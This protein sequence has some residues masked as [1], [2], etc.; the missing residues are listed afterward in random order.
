MSVLEKALEFASRGLRV[1]PV[2]KKDPQLKKWPD[3]ATT[4]QETIRSWFE[5]KYDYCD[6]FG[7]CPGREAV[8]IDVDVKNGKKGKESLAW[9]KENGLPLKTFVVKSP[10]GGLHLYYKFPDIPDGQY[11]KSVV[12]WLDLDGIDVRGTRGFVVGPTE[13][14]GY[15]IVQDLEPSVIP[16]DIKTRLPIGNVL[17]E[18]VNTKSA[19]Q[20][21]SPEGSALRGNIPN[22]IPR[23]ERHDT[24]I[25]LI[26]SWARKVS[27]DNA[28]ILL[29]TAI[30]R[31]EGLDDD[32]I[33]V[34]DYMPRLDEAYKKFDPV[35]EDKLDWMLDNLVLIESGPRVY[36]ISRPGNI[37]TSNL[38]EAKNFFANWI[39]WEEKEDGSTKPIPVFDRWLKHTARKSSPQV[40]YKPV[41]ETYYH[42]NVIGSTI[43]NSYR[44]PEHVIQQ[45][46]VD[47]KPFIE[48][49]YFLLE[50]DTET[51]L[52]WCAHLIQQPHKKI[53]WAPVIVSTRE[54]M[55]KNTLFN[56]ISHMIGPWNAVNITAGQFLKTFNT[57]LVS[58]VLVLINELEEVD[59]KKR[60]EI[61][62]K[63]RGYITESKQSIEPKGVDVYSTEIY[64][65][66]ILFSNKEDAVHISQDSR[67]F[68]VHIN[69][70]DPRPES[71]YKE[72]HRWLQEGH[73]YDAVYKFLSTRDISNFA[74]YGR[75]PETESKTEMVKAGL[76]TE[77]AVLKEAIDNRYSVFQSDIVTRDSL[78]YFLNFKLPRGIVVSSGRIKHILRE[79]FESLPIP[80]QSRKGRQIRLNSIDPRSDGDVLVRGEP[81]RYV[82]YTCRNY[83]MWAAASTEAITAEY[84]KVFKME[85]RSNA[86]KVVK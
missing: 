27:Y 81:D 2:H 78:M 43:V 17:T 6:S 75:A 23:G 53:A 9:L 65:N 57:F 24:L 12:G 22:V 28:I 51:F 14:N 48:F 32:P 59:T 15:K 25:R 76:T 16:E 4:D 73:G 49:V 58:S 46:T 21:V 13:D 33:L 44:A 35:I 54:G 64:T 45:E 72:L 42:C 10:S 50:E 79:N 8:V 3:L 60:H 34:Q 29:E 69:Y 56:I 36:N 67:R 62:S 7:V 70:N 11:I 47:V 37:G 40:G 19:E 52:D 55:G 30:S 80:S 86:L 61:S 83:N 5:G 63:L 1:F 66:F 74:W 84:E 26:A 71:Y 20:L 77:E 41:K 39:H 82:V 68:F 38:I 18:K 31:C 85:T